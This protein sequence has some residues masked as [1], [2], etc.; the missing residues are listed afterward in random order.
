MTYFKTISFWNK[1]NHSIQ[2]FGTGSQVALVAAEASHVW[3]YI[4]AAATT[5]AM[6]LTIWAADENK[7]GLVDAFEKVI[8][9][10]T[11]PDAEVTIETEIKKTEP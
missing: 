9:V 6:L 2:L 4:A 7:N 8:T 3:N 11:H 10:T 1:L 5:T